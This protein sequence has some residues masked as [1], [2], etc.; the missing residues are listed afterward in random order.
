[1]IL[2]W[3]SKIQ[4]Q[5][6]RKAS[7]RPNFYF[8]AQMEAHPEKCFLYQSAFRLQGNVNFSYWNYRESNSSCIFWHHT[9]LWP[10]LTYLDVL[11]RG[12]SRVSEVFWCIILGVIDLGSPYLVAQNEFKI[13]D[14]FS[15]KKAMH[16]HSTI[17]KFCVACVSLYTPELSSHVWCQILCILEFL[18]RSVCSLLLVC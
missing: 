16:G 12:D 1:M 18:V 5:S 11:W 9:F 2:R 13:S 17:T 3:N 4:S 7:A 10:R 6:I 15:C 8:W 14:V